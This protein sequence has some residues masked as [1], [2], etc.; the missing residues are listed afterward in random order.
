MGTA[1]PNVAILHTSSTGMREHS[2]VDSGDRETSSNLIINDNITIQIQR[3]IACVSDRDF[4]EPMCDNFDTRI[5]KTMNKY[6]VS[7]PLYITVF[8]TSYRDYISK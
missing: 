7:F 8:I 2:E 5:L 4:V 3:I 1:G 6:R